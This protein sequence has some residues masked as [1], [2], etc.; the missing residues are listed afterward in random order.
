MQLGA[1]QRST[2]MAPMSQRF[3]AA[4]ERFAATASIS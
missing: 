4:M 1:R 3:V 2:V